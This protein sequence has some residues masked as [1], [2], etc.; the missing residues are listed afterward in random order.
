[1]KTLRLLALS[2]VISFVFL[3]AAVAEE[4]ISKIFKDVKPAVVLIVVKDGAGKEMGQ[5]TGFLIDNLHVITNY[6][7]IDSA[8]SA[9]V[10]T[11]DGKWYEVKGI[12]ASDQISDLANLALTLK[13]NSI[14]PLKLRKKEPEEGQKVI[15]L[16]NPLGLEST[17]SDG[18]ISAIRDIP[19]TGKVLQI[20][21]PISPGSSGSPVLNIDGEVIGVAKA[22]IIDGQNLNFAIRSQDV[23][24]LNKNKASAAEP[25]NSSKKPADYK[26]KA[27][28]L[29]LSGKYDEALPLLQRWTKDEPDN[30]VAHFCLG[31]SYDSLNQT[32]D[33][34][35][36]YKMAIRLKPD[37]SDYHC[38]LGL[39]YDSL[40]QTKDA[41]DEYKMAIRLK[42]D[43]AEYHYFLG[44]AYY[45]SAQYNLAIEEYKIAI[46]LKPDY[47]EAHYNLGLT[48][49]ILEDKSSALDE[50]KIL[51]KLDIERA[52][53]LFDLIYPAN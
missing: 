16:G 17:I 30:A 34:I 45:T 31:D 27:M 26:V 25:F 41:I 44:S 28:A 53:K 13:I 18:I 19:G 49:L 9:S 48:Y 38:F 6:H 2:I 32:K 42:P 21:A 29:Y 3:Q 35:D 24:I 4:T 39:T 50:Y 1:M 7:V 22:T 8:A 11:S 14:T 23:I 40:N 20:T 51:Q 5:G 37:D 33:A 47:A 46:R 10:K 43:V 15:V 36:E 52:K 12:A